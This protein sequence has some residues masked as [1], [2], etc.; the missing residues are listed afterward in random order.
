MLKYIKTIW[1]WDLWVSII[2]SLAIS[3]TWHHWAFTPTVTTAVIAGVAVTAGA[4]TY[5]EQIRRTVYNTIVD[6][7][8]FTPLFKKVD[9][10]QHRLAR[11]FTVTR[12]VC[13][14]N[15]PST[16]A[17]ALVLNNETVSVALQRVSVGISSGLFLWTIT[18]IISLLL[19]QEEFMRLAFAVKRL[20]GLESENQVSVSK[21]QP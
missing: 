12:W 19:L 4:L 21:R 10:D 16:V 7:R 6:D 11:V 20:D 17:T 9:H 18:A 1:Y 13:L 14:A 8:E 15:L 3:L 2:I 5:T